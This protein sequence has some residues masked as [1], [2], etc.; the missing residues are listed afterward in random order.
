LQVFFVF[1]VVLLQTFIQDASRAGSLSWILVNSSG[2]NTLSWASRLQALILFVSLPWH[3][4]RL[5]ELA[6]HNHN[7]SSHSI[8]LAPVASEV[9]ICNLWFFVLLQCWGSN[10]GSCVC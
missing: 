3:W 1:V 4:G 7:T 9:N 8:H 10:P 6:R 5:A 2:E